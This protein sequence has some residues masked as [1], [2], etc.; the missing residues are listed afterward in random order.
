MEDSLLAAFRAARY[1]FDHPDGELLLAVDVPSPALAAL[2]RSRGADCMAVLTAFNP[3]G[4]RQDHASNR[5]AQD[6][7]LQ[8]IQSAGHAFLPGRNEDPAGQWPAEESFL[9]PGISATAAL[10]LAVRYRQ[11]AFLWT[12][13]ATA[14]PRLIWTTAPAR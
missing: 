11:L 6:L 8:D 5:I 3:Q 1:R 14:T 9:V 4:R 10:A 13:A 12:D 7:L 2:L